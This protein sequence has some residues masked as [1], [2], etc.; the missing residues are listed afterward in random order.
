MAKDASGQGGT[1][2]TSTQKLCTAPRRFSGGN[3]TVT[4]TKSAHDLAS[5]GMLLLFV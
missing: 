1:P 5:D 4:P 2:N 3:V